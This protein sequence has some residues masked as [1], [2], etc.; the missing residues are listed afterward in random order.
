MHSPRSRAMPPVRF[1]AALA[2]AA[3]VLACSAPA[4]AKGRVYVSPAEDGMIAYT[5]EPV[6]KDS[7]LYMTVS[8]PPA[9]PRQRLSSPS[10]QTSAAVTTAYANLVTPTIQQLNECSGQ[11]IQRAA[12]PAAGCHA[13]RVQFQPSGPLAGRSDRFDADHASHG[14]P[15]WGSA[16]PV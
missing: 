10:L 11:G 13:C 4:I 3:L 7:E 5:D 16:K 15:V 12:R 2:F 8:A 6:G 9:R 14:R 1:W